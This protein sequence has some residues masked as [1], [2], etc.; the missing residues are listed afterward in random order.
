MSFFYILKIF[1]HYKR[2]NKVA[3]VSFF[4]LFLSGASRQAVTE[5]KS[6]SNS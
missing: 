2:K 1:I 5:M 6:G 4:S 3:P